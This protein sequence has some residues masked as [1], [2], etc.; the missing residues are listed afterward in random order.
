MAQILG[1]CPDTVATRFATS[2]LQRYLTGLQVAMKAINGEYLD[3]ELWFYRLADFSPS[4]NE[5][6][7]AI[8]LPV[9][10]ILGWSCADEFIPPGSPD[11]P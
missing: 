1:S 9:G 4:L 10:G 3:E 8:G 5:T 7:F 2:H 11:G 6:R